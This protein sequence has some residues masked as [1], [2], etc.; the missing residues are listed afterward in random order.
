MCE[1]QEQVRPISLSTLHQVNTEP[2]L[3]S[4]ATLQ[5]A[6]DSWVFKNP[7]QAACLG[8]DK[9]LLLVFSNQGTIPENW[10]RLQSKLTL[11]WRESQ[12]EFWLAPLRRWFLGERLRLRLLLVLK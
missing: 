11:P 12:L 7:A 3:L 2:K 6:F 9:S 4:R 10:K 8:F 1:A 5:R